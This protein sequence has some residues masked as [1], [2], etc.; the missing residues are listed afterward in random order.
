ML[1]P[2][3]IEI[4][5]SALLNNLRVLKG[6]TGNA[7]FCPMVKANGYGH[8][9]VLIARL[10]EEFGQASAIG[11]ALIE[12]GLRLRTAGITLPIL[13]LAPFDA[14][15]AAQ[16]RTHKLTPVVGRL[17]DLDALLGETAVHLKFNTGMQRLGFDREDLPRLRARLKELVGVK[18]E[19]LCTHLTHGDEARD[20]ISFTSRQIEV[21]KELSQGFPGQRHLHKSSS[22]CVLQERTARS[23]LGARPGISIYGLPHDGRANGPGLQPVL[24]WKT[25]LTH[26]HSVKA[27]TDVGYGARFQTSRPSTIGVV[28]VGYGDGYVR[29]LGVGKSQ[30][31]FRGLRVPVVGSV[32]MDYTLLD[33]TD[34]CA[35]GLARPGESVVLIGKQGREEIAAVELAERAGTISYEVVTA[36]SRRVRR[37]AV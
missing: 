20:E 34:A 17:Q 25:E 11:V 13:V 36:I 3:C 32:C 19:G 26:I 23:G 31:L 12:E 8:D 2:T 18:V 35:E 4:E 6:W 28:P 27:G 30:M 9:E 22:L 16:M 33:L 5:R 21:F 1:R 14:E 37:E 24:T 10:V 29:A 7:F 15:G